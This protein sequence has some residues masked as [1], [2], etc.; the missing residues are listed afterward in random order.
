MQKTTS[1]EHTTGTTCTLV[2]YESNVF[3]CDVDFS[4]ESRLSQ[5]TEF[6]LISRLYVHHH[7]SILGAIGEGGN[8]SREHAPNERPEEHGSEMV[9]PGRSTVEGR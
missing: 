3:R 8:Q 2:E 6:E 1:R 7:C 9:N 4:S 5:T